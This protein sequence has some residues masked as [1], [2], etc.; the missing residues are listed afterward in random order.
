MDIDWIIV[1]AQIANFAALVWLLHRF[2]YEPIVNA[3]SARETA[4]Q[5]RFDEA[6]TLQTDAA[7]QRQRYEAKRADLEE[8]R[9]Q[10]LQAAREE[11]QQTLASLLEEAQREARTARTRLAQQLDVERREMEHGLQEGIIRQAGAASESLL[12]QLAGR[13]VADGI[14]DA[15]AEQLGAKQSLR[16]VA[17]VEVRTSFAPDEGQRARIRTILQSVVGADLSADDVRFVHDE[18]L[19]LGLELH[20]DGSVVSW[21]ARRMLDEWEMDALER[22]A[23]DGGGGAADDV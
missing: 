1:L 20:Y 2:L 3:I 21:H 14:I 6:R 7:E 4:L 22:I 23:A 9:A 11:A 18:S 10:Y 5:E 8:T 13:S 17:P 19:V 15:F 16:V 12:R